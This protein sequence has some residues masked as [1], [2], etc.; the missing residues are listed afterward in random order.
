MKLAFVQSRLVNPTALAM[1]PLQDLLDL[2]SEARMNVPGSADGNWRW[3]V[4]ENMRSP[5]AFKR[6]KDLTESSRRSDG[7]AISLRW[8]T[9]STS[10]EMSEI[11]SDIIWAES[12]LR[13]ATIVMRLVGPASRCRQQLL[14]S[15]IE[16]ASASFSTRYLPA[17]EAAL[18]PR[19]ETFSNSSGSRRSTSLYLCLSRAI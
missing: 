17:V 15:R 13:P 11:G 12:S 7:P 1:P 9:S 19:G 10:R 8:R 16:S 2:G 18:N 6:L 14:A 5:R 3:R 4:R